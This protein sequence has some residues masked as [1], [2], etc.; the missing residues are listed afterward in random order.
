M[1]LAGRTG[2]FLIAVIPP[3]SNLKFFVVQMN[4]QKVLVY[5]RSK[6]RGRGQIPHLLYRN[7][8]VYEVLSAFIKRDLGDYTKATER[9]WRKQTCK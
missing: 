9:E 7:G 1:S 3:S 8:I 4:P 6:F 2:T 5:K